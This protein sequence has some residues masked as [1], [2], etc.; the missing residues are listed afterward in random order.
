MS[1]GE[2]ERISSRLHTE[3]GAQQL[4]Y[5][6]ANPPPPRNLNTH[7]IFPMT[8]SSRLGRDGLKDANLRSAE[9]EEAG[10]SLRAQGNKTLPSKGPWTAVQGPSFPAPS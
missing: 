8:L 10:C 9:V 1:G 3:P 2:R 6:G 7:F 4:S 5:P